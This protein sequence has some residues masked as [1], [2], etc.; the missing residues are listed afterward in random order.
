[1]STLDEY[2]A[3]GQALRQ[4]VFGVPAPGAKKSPTQELAPDLG[5]IS[6]EVLFGQVWSRPGLEL[7]HRSMITI[8]ALTALG[9]EPELKAHIR[10][11]LNVG[12][13]REQIVEIILQIVVLRGAAGGPR[14]VQG[15]EG[16]VR[17]ARRGEPVADA[18]DRAVLPRRRRWPT[19]DPP[20]RTMRRRSG[21]PGHREPHPAESVPASSHSGGAGGSRSP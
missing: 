12:L 7:A 15:G 19:L 10:G 5:R 20:S 3:K 11:G 13:T 8:A 21:P 14:R 16:G 17:P 9:R 6:D 4:T 2:R 1:M 18:Q